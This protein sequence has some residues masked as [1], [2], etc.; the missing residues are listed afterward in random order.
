MCLGS[1]SVGFPGSINTTSPIT[2]TT[3]VTSS[4]TESYDEKNT[5]CGKVIRA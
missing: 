3:I 2:I 4:L 1:V 5:Y